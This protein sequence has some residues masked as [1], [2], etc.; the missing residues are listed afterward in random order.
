MAATASRSRLLSEA[1]QKL[2]EMEFA[3]AEATISS[4]HA[5]ED[6]DRPQPTIRDGFAGLRKLAAEQAQLDALEAQREKICSLERA[7]RKPAPPGLTL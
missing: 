5:T 7:P 3:W 1:R 6:P 4:V 2:T